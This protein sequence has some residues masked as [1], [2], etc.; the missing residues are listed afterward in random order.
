MIFYK[1]S[2]EEARIFGWRAFLYAVPIEKYIYFCTSLAAKLGNMIDV[3]P[4][5]P[6]Q[7]P[8]EENARHASGHYLPPPPLVRAPGAKR[9]GGGRTIVQVGNE[10]T[11]KF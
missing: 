3:S 9:R 8:Y 1:L 6:I 7:A 5:L 4:A 11:R 2:V 10:D